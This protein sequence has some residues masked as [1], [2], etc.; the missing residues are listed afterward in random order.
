[1]IT[2]PGQTI[3]RDLPKEE[4]SKMFLIAVIVILIFLYNYQL[5][6]VFSF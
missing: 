2:I 1:M 6:Y 3:N 5:F 4:L